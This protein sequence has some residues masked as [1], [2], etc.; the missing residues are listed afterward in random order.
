MTAPI[1]SFPIYKSPFIIDTDASENSL[2]AVESNVF[3]GKERPLAFMSRI[4]S[5]T[6]SNY[7]TTKRE[8][9]GVVQAMKSFRPYILGCPIII[10]TDHSS[11]TCLFRQN[12]D[13]MIVKMIQK[14][15]EFNFTIVH[16]PEIKHAN[17]D[18]LSRREEDIPEWQEGVQEVLR[19]QTPELN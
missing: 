8:A 15:Q 19:G 3:N 18:G 7:A 9:L 10:C 14:L 2:G 12:A 4:L 13:G 6:E 5:K 1:L 17:A 16:R 11:L